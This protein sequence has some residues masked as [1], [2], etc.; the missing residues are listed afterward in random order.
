MSTRKYKKHIHEPV[1]CYEVETNKYQGT[2]C[3][4]C[5]KT[6]PDSVL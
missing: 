4:K 5:F 3:W 2:F 6:L 1:K